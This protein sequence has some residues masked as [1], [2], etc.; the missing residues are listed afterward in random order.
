MKNK[1]DDLGPHPEG[2]VK[3]APESYPAPQR[4]ETFGGVVEVRWEE[5]P[6]V[7]MHGGLAYFVEFLKVSGIWEKFVKECPL[8]YSSPNAPDKSEILGTILFSVLSG[9]RRY[10]H[11]TGI[12]GDVVLPEL[13]DIK[14]FRSEDSVRRA[15]EK[16]DE[17]KLTLW[18]DGQMSET[19][20]ALL[21]QAWILD[22]DAT[23]KTL[24]G[25]QEEA[26][27]GYNPMKPGRPSHVYHAMVMT[28]AKLVVNVD[29]EAGNRIASAYALP[30]LWGWLDA[31]EEKDWPTLVRGDIAYGNEE[32][33]TGCEQR[34]LAYLFKLRQSQRVAQLLGKLARQG[35]KAGWRDAGQGWEGV[36]QELQLQGWKAARRVIVSRRKLKA[37][38][39]AEADTAQLSLPG[40]T[41]QHKGGELYEYAVLVTNW[42]ERDL[43]AVAQTYRDRA[44]AENLFDE[45]KN[46]WGW[47]GFT[48]QDLKRSQLMARMVALIYNWWCI[49]T[50]M[51][52]GETHGEA[53]TTRPLFQQAIAR[54]T[55]HANQTRLY[56]SSIH[57]KARQAAHLLDRIS[58]WL[59]LF[60][61]PA[62]QLGSKSGWGAMLRRIFQD[63]G[64]FLFDPA[65]EEGALV[66][67]NCRI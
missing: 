36:E 38:I 58:T 65:P 10:A 31:H 46:Q 42:P 17:E 56:I 62:E 30:T 37:D 53:I 28:A 44:G 52:T 12:R 22:L 24:Y 57:A 41:I 6:G 3:T 35:G 11:I 15:F 39:E 66:P 32:M 34:G 27:V 60:V 45:L 9:H 50:R 23:V 40:A 1:A 59:K 19:Y 25:R 43:L 29:A 63:F 64:K 4:L 2:E 67:V 18:M 7:S 55:R 14:Q 61:Q 47:T 51:G 13:L 8:E 16:Q 20:A 48:T 5:D 54:R 33:M 21:D 49:F 26:R